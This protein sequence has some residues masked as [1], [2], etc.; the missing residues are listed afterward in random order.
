M[1]TIKIEGII[2]WEIEA[3]DIR[4]QLEIADGEDVLVEI[5]SPGGLIS[6]G[7][8]IY[9]TLKN[10]EGTVNTHLMGAVAS[11]A[12][13]ITMIGKHRTAENN[14]VFMIHN[15]TG[16]AWGDHHV[17]FKFG[18]YLDS[19]SN[20]IAKEFAF[21]SETDLAEI[22][23][24]MDETTFY[25]GDEIK[26]A[27][28]VHEMVGDVEPEDRAE[29]VAMAELMIAECQTKINTPEMVK[30]D[31]TALAT[32]MAD[33]PDLVE[34]KEQ[35]EKFMA[36]HLAKMMLSDK[37][38][39]PK[40]KQIQEGKAM[41]LEEMKEKYPELYN[42]IMALGQ[43]EGVT[44]ERERVKLLV[45]MRAKFPKAHSQKVI[46]AAIMEGHD[47]SQVSINL[48]S[49]DQAAAEVEKVRADEAIPPANG[50]DVPEMKDGIMTHP[51]H[52]DAVG[53][54]IANLPGVM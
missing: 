37:I 42:Q 25:Y 22:R 17:M 14:A 5:A 23:S 50:E 20:V 27:G 15:G 26:E 11:M 29:A 21:K 44:Q 54:Q 13:Y 2:G 38:T 45:E 1:H 32:M 52:V 28:F 8:L 40:P 24:A 35:I 16:I 34:G 43:A 39:K 6:E 41:T 33:E 19:L 49:A 10:Y 48:M 18:K 12:S 7:L 51:D 3:K 31:M 30:K 47:L 4:E 9:N 36:E 46:D 53:A